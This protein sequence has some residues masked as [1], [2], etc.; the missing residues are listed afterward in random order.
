MAS[1]DARLHTADKGRVLETMK[2]EPEIARRFPRELQELK[3]S[4]ARVI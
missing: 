1:R 3:D 2:E 4:N